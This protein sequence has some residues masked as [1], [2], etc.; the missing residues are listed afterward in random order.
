MSLQIHT[1]IIIN[2]TPE[3]VWSVFSDFAAYPEWNSFIKSIRGEVE[4][5]S[6]IQVDIDGMKFSP[7]VLRFTK[8]EEFQWKGKLFIPGLFDGKHR[9]FLSRNADGTTLFVQEEEFSGIL[10]PFLRGKLQNDILPKFNRMNEE[11]KVRAERV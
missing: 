1:S 8:N 2:A 5:N 3:K 11:L 7:R 6:T 10:I 9:F 4:I